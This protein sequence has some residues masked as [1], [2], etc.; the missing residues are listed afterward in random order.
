MRK[1]YH[2]S[3]V[4]IVIILCLV[5][6]QLVPYN[7]T[8]NISL[9]DDTHIIETHET[10]NLQPSINTYNIK[11][12]NESTIDNGNSELE[13]LQGF[14]MKSTNV[15][16]N[17]DTN[18]TVLTSLLEGSILTLYRYNSNWY[19]LTVQIDDESRI[20]YLYAND[21]EEI[22]SDPKKLEGVTIKQPTAVYEKPTKN[23]KI[24][25]SYNFNQKLTYRTFSP[26]WYE[27]TI[28]VNE[29]LITGYIHKDDVGKTADIKTL[30]GIAAAKQTNVYSEASRNSKIVKTYKLGDILELYNYD[31]NWFI[32]T[33]SMNGSTQIGFI[34]VKDVE[35]AVS[36]PKQLQRVVPKN[37]IYAYETASTQ[38][39]KLKSFSYGQILTLRTFTSNWY[40]IDIAMNGKTRT[41]YIRHS[42]VK[43]TSTSLKGFA[44]SN[45]T[46]V[47]SSTPKS[48]K[49]IKS[50][51]KGHILKYKPYRSNWFRATVYVNGKKQTGYIHASNVSP[52]APTLTGY[53][54]KSPTHVYSSKSKKTKKLKNYKKGH[55][56]KFKPIDNNW[57]QATVYVNGKKK[58]GYLHKND[59]T[60][61]PFIKGYAIATPTY[62]YSK[63]SKSS[64]K[65]KKYTR[66]RTIQYQPYNK[67][68]YKVTVIVKGKKKTGYIHINDAGIVNPHK[69]YTYNNMASDI[70]K[71]QQA[72]P[73]LI[74][75]KVVGKSE[76][77]RNIYAVSLGK[78]KATAFINGSHH[79]REWLTTN[80][81]MYMIEQYAKAYEKNS[82]IKGYNARNILNE[83]TLWFIPMVN[84]DGVTL[85]QFGL[86]AFPK[87]THK[88]LIK[89]N[90]G[91]KNFK[92]WKANAKGVDLNRQYNAGWK[93]IKNNPGKPYYQNY[94]GKKPHTAAET[95]AVLKLVNEIEPQMAVSYHSSG[96]IIFWN[97]D[98]PMAN[99]LRDH[100]YAKRISKLTGYSLVYYPRG[101]V[102]SGGGFTDWFI[103][104]KKRP[105]FTP[106]ISRYVGPTNP[107]VSAFPTIWKEN[108]AVGLYVAQESAKLYKNAFK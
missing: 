99:Y 75:Y 22:E 105:A 90:N 2:F 31:N 63:T 104:T 53:A 49:K 74:T 79:A 36:P 41:G 92:R 73:G 78:G 38:S 103:H 56:L 54:A 27:V 100:V 32:T 6:F 39:K 60:D 28:L 61:K 17:P 50:Y 71:L 59:I 45:P 89:M 65:I 77:G 84:P 69:T 20:G 87:S 52:N 4:N 64:K 14:T 96:R 16:S 85:Q 3:T 58:T 12:N 68:W 29:S 57:Y 11:K 93:T 106:E 30:R 15:Y 91:S 62:V 43:N 108:Q 19:Q 88:A 70:K 107:P 40:E 48:S 26:Q 67:N 18:S 42:D 76:Y 102:P 23:A 34:H 24:L 94:K 80:L 81:N 95:K 33:I 86:Q 51:K 82:S 101:Y 5:F 44:I 25:K 1:K 47:Y 98:Q 8:A 55:K 10:S 7:A 72:Y 97:Y 35:T 9:R 37:T 83:T 21:I 13:E 46:Y 66:G